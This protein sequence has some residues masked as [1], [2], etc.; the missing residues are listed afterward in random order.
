MNLLNELKYEFDLSYIFISHD[1]SV[2]RFMSDRIMV[3]KEGQ[4]MEEG[5]TNKV[6]EDPQHAYT[7]ELLSAVPKRVLR[8]SE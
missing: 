4:I 2:V 3:M 6:V 7:R 5:E 8:L 1:L